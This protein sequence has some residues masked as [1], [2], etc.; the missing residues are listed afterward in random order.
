[1]VAPRAAKP[2][3]RFVDEYCASY[4][5]LFADV[6]SFEAFKHLHVGAIAEIP[7][8][9]LPAVAKVNGLPNAQSLQQ[10]LVGSPWQV[11]KLR[12]KR[13]DL[14]LKLL[15]GRKL[16]L[17]ID[18]TGDRKKGRTT[19]YVKRQYIGNLGKVAYSPNFGNQSPLTSAA[20]RA[21]LRQGENRQVCRLTI[22]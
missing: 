21:Q 13:L 16:I 22:S 17:V 6:R 4:Q 3:V 20:S 15:K 8:K 9:S 12:E 19:D 1:M 2:T 7:R 5:D 14:I 10:F 18:E 11:E